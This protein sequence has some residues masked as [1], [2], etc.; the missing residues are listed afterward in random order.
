MELNRF[1]HKVQHGVQEFIGQD[2][3]VEAKKIV[4]NNNVVLDGLV[5]MKKGQNISPTIYLNDYFKEYVQGKPISTIVCEIMKLYEEKQLHENFNIDFFMDY[6][7]VRS[8]IA[9]KL[10]HYKRNEQL[11]REIPHIPFLDLAIVFYCIVSDDTLGNATIL[12]YQNHCDMWNVTVHDIYE[13]AK[14]NMP[15]LLPHFIQNMEDLVMDMLQPEDLE[16]KLRVPMYILTNR[17]KLFGASCIL[18]EGVLEAF[19]AQFGVDIYI[20]PSSV[21]EVILIPNQGDMDSHQLEAMV[22]EVN[23]TQLEEQEILSDTVYCYDK[24]GG[25]FGFASS[26]GQVE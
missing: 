7:K 24:R 16:G 5:I 10:I 13:V 21:H 14:K 25:K 9:Y 15:R 2:V 11:L 6:E 23:E 12:I 8:R 17:T 18:Y 22:H 19:A 1:I 20:L 3:R 26:V 4:K